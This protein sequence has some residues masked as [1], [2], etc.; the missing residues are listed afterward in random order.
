MTHIS[1][2]QLQPPLPVSP[3]F[4]SD[5]LLTLAQQA[6]DAGYAKAARRLLRLA[7]TVLDEPSRE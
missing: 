3:L 6:D 1:Q 4:I 2:I 5:R 7:I